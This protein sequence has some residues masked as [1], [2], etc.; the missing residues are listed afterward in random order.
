MKNAEEEEERN[1]CVV[2]GGEEEER[3]RDEYHLN[4]IFAVK[5]ALVYVTLN[6]TANWCHLVHP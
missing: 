5:K 4:N 6:A 1:F 3:E 2:G